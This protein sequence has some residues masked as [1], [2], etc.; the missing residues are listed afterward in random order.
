MTGA[1]PSAGAA[2]T[3]S[4]PSVMRDLLRHEPRARRLLL[5]HAQSALGSGAGSVALLVLTYARFRSPVAVSTMLLCDLA[6]AMLLG[7]LVGALADRWPRR[8]LL[9]G[10]DLLRAG[11]FTGLALAGSFPAMIAFALAGGLGTAL[12][13]P[14]VMATLPGLVRKERLPAATRPHGALREFGFAVG[15]AL[16]AGALLITDAR[17]VLL[18]NAATFALS[19]ALI[20]AIPCGRAALKRK[21]SLRQA[22]RDG[23]DALRAVPAARTVVLSS[24]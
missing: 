16:A 4:T 2:P 14:T 24:T 15:P 7:A 18:A 11:A 6:P 21:P 23:A 1:A 12:F 17:G 3:P 10:G 20:T 22:L 13:H 8:A 19:A 9:I 5:A